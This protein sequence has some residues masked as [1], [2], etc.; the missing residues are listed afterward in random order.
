AGLGGRLPVEFE[1][2]PGVAS[3]GDEL[4]GDVLMA[5]DAGVGAG[6]E[7]VKVAESAGDFLGVGHVG[8]G[9][10]AQP[11]AGRAVA[12]DAGNAFGGAGVGAEEGGLHGGRGLGGC[13]AGGAAGVGG[14]VG[15]AKGFGHAG[16]AGGGQGGVGAGV[17]VAPTPDGVLVMLF[18][19]PAVAAA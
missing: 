18:G 2:E 5:G 15:Y 10:A 1:D 7:V 13:V 6:V 17:G 11:F 4:R 9:V 3:D 12:T 14:G 19:G 16:R 8:A